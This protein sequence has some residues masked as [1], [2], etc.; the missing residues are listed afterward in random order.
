MASAAPPSPAWGER[1]ELPPELMATLARPPGGLVAIAATVDADGSP[2]TATFGVI[3][4][5]SPN[6]LRFGCRREHATYANLQRDGRVM[7]AIHAPGVAV[8]VGGRATV[9]RDHLEAMPSNARIHL[10]VEVVKN[11][12]VP[13]LPV[14]GGVVYGMDDERRAQLDAVARELEADI[15]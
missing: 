4:A 2:R 9:V 15:A 13:T 10:D 11:D 12:T 14:T 3:R 7:L 6:Q 1:D 5:A 8:G